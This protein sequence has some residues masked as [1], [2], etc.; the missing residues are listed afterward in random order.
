MLLV[1]DTTVLVDLWRLRRE[2]NRLADL[3]EKLIEPALP[4]P[5]VFEFARGAAF[6][7]VTRDK[8]DAF[9]A[10]FAFLTPDIDEILRASWI[11]ADL[12]R[13]GQE[14]GASDV[15]IATAA[16]QR[17]PAVLTANV[18]HFTRIEGLNV[19][20]YKILP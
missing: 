19:I 18:G 3:R 17:N 5:V 15:W 20:E 10:G 13:R 4:L 8:L 1:T 9:L 12:R 11:E 16:L 7:G 6:R 2:P 14:I